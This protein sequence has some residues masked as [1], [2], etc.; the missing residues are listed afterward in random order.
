MF[1]MVHFVLAYLFCCHATW[2]K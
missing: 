2:F 1:S